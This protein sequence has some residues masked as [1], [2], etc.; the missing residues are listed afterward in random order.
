MINKLRARNNTRNST[1]DTDWDDVTKQLQTKS[2]MDQPSSQIKSLFA[3]REAALQ[4][5][6]VVILEY[7]RST[8]IS[9]IIDFFELNEND[10]TWIHVSL[11]EQTTLTLIG[12]IDNAGVGNDKVD[13][14][15]ITQ[16]LK[17]AGVDGPRYVRVVIPVDIVEKGT[18]QDFLDYFKKTQDNEANVQKQ[19]LE[20]MSQQVGFDMSQLTED[21]RDRLMSTLYTTKDK[22]IKRQ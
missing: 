16:A 21:Q 20:Q 12:A 3:L 2:P 19:A 11:T 13:K 18:K 7:L 14:D 6:T 5:C 9:A 17:T 8:L 4:E 15:A 22:E 10:I 1:N